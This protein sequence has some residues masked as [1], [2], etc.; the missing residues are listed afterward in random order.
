MKRLVLTLIVL[1]G[2]VGATVC[3]E[4]RGEYDREFR[5]AWLHTVYQP[6][7]ARQSTE[8]N[9]AYLRRQ[10]DSLQ[11]AGINAVVFQ[12]RPS[13]DAF[14]RSR[15]EPWSRFL[16]G[17]AGKAPSPMWDPLEFMIAES[18]S[19]G[20]ELHAWLNP[21]RV[22]TSRSEK[23]PQGHLWYSDPSRFVE[24][25][26]KLYFDPGQPANR[27]FIVDVGRD[28]ISRYDVDGIHFDDY[29]YPYPV[30][31]KTFGDSVSY[32]R[33][34]AGMKLGDWRR[35]NVD[36]LIKDIHS[37]I[38]AEKPWVRFG[39]SPFG[40]WRNASSDPD[41]SATNGLQNYD[42][43]YADVLLWASNGWVDY[44]MPQLYWALDHPRASYTVLLDWWGRHAADRHLY[45]GQDIGVTMKTP[46]G[47]EATQLRRKVAMTRGNKAV[48][49][50]CWWPGYQIS[51]NHLGVADSLTAD[52][53]RVKV[54]PPAM[55]W[56]SAVEPPQPQGLTLS[57]APGGRKVIRWQGEALNAPDGVDKVNR[58]GVYY[59]P[60]LR[61]DD[62]SGHPAELIGVVYGNE[63]T[64][65]D[66]LE[67]YFAVTAVSRSNNESRPSFINVE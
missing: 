4:G 53:Q 64:V 52:L 1:W 28:I 42:D 36:S 13:A 57:C 7:Y 22:T 50:N 14:Y 9:K 62:S 63:F 45:I 26:G 59:S 67:G 61:L 46:V 17:T 39:V 8:Q 51:A 18:H 2:A 19:R 29:F 23:L 24:Y 12:V 47:S 56:M 66:G 16:T 48:Q 49:G 65:P 11:Q 60:L 15:L 25:D 37:A 43:L 30:K 20:M 5:G 10:L 35:S 32:A 6:Q 33:Y 44:L 27:R 3:A 34:G 40:I 41:G 55:S 21:Y 38:A 54:L 58:Y 31:D